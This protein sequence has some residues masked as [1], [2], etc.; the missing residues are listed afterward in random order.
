M[1]IKRLFSIFFD[2]YDW[3]IREKRLG[4]YTKESDYTNYLGFA[5]CKVRGNKLIYFCADVVSSDMLE[6]KDKLFYEPCSFIHNGVIFDGSFIDA[7][8]YIK[9]QMQTYRDK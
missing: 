7:L 8:E 4:D 9:K 1:E 3:E 6:L 5:V 2:E